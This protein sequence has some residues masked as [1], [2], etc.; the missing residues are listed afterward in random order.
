MCMCV[1]VYVGVCVQEEVAKLTAEIEARHAKELAE[2][3]ECF[4]CDSSVRLWLHSHKR[5][6]TQYHLT[7]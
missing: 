6:V 1:C 2:V 7:L 4:H 3:R 5:A